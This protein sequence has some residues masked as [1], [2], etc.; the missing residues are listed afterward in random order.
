MTIVILLLLLGLIPA[1][2]ASS[3]GRSFAAWWLFGAALFIVALPMALMAGPAGAKRRCPYCAE[4]VRKEAVIC[5]H[6]RQNIALPR[7]IG[8]LG[9]L[10]FRDQP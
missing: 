5:P 9:R 7:R 4:S 6:C 1:A 8:P 2:I 10:F 3:K